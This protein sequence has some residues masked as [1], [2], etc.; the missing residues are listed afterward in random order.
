MR[1]MSKR[2]IEVNVMLWGMVQAQVSRLSDQYGTQGDTW[3]H[4]GPLFGE[5]FGEVC[6]TLRNDKK[7]SLAGSMNPVRLT[8]VVG[9]L[10]MAVERYRNFRMDAGKD[11]YTFNAVSEIRKHVATVRRSRPTYARP[12]TQYDMST[13]T[14]LC[15]IE[16]EYFLPKLAEAIASRSTLTIAEASY[17]WAFHL[18]WHMRC[19]IA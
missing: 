15:T 8:E 12:L 4:W 18:L 6:T 1:R 19:N 13:S 3:V 11:S 10:S 17:E 16:P 2:D 5:E 7:N 14:N 9:I